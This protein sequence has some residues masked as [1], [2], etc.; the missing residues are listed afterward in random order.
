M[1]TMYNA[2]IKATTD[3]LQINY[4][5]PEWPFTTLI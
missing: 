5:P 3:Q 4:K 2:H 1:C